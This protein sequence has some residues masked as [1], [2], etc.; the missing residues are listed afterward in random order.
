[1]LFAANDLLN[2]DLWF[3]FESILAKF[4]LVNCCLIET[5]VKIII[6]LYVGF[7]LSWVI[8]CFKELSQLFKLIFRLTHDKKGG[9]GIFFFLGMAWKEDIDMVPSLFLLI[10][11]ITCLIIFYLFWSNHASW[12]FL[13]FL[14]GFYCY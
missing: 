13:F 8:H 1:M 9:I 4:N 6:S 5:V 12:S 10:L 7:T 14:D 2:N 3:S 11:L